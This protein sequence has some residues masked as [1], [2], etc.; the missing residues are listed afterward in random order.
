MWL[1]GKGLLNKLDY[2]SNS[3]IYCKVKQVKDKPDKRKILKKLIS[4][5][6]CKSIRKNQVF[7]HKN[8]IQAQSAI[9]ISWLKIRIQHTSK[10]LQKQYKKVQRNLLS[11]LQSLWISFTRVIKI[12]LQRL[13]GSMKQIQS[14]LMP[15][16]RN[17]LPFWTVWYHMEAS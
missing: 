17:Y 9:L 3:L 15:K 7:P 14:L 13:N 5:Q 4:K 8:K 16:S 10:K 11:N 1:W 2:R 12:S 6:S